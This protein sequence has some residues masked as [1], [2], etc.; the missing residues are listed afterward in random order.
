M[1]KIILTLAFIFL[2]AINVFPTTFEE[3]YS[4]GM[5]PIWSNESIHQLIAEYEAKLKSDNSDYFAYLALGILYFNLAS[6][7]S[8]H[9][10]GSVQKLL[11]YTDKFLDKEPD[12]SLALIY[13]GLG[14]GFIARDTSESN[15][16]VKL[17]EVNEAVKICDEAVNLAAG[18][19]YEWKIRYMRASFY[20]KLPDLF[21]ERDAAIDDFRFVE[22]QYYKNTNNLDIERVMS[23]V[24]FNLRRTVISE[25]NKK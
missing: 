24:N 18:K 20:I 22:T 5:S 1:K 10:G 14:H 21:K 23:T 11:D 8:T 12:N 4:L 19:N 9:E 3:C 6:P 16:L 7:A 17:T 13:N 2:Y 25:T 15:L